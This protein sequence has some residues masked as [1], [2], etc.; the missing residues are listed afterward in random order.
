MTDWILAIG[1]IL[2]WTAF[3]GVFLVGFLTCLGHAHWFVAG[4]LDRREETQL[5]DHA[6]RAKSELDRRH[7]R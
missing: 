4:W 3:W 7:E 6:M 2:A 1:E 5:V